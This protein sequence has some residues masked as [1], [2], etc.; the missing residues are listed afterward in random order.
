MAAKSQYLSNKVL[1]NALVNTAYTPPGTV[2][3]A[4]NTTAS[5][6]TAP[7][8]E[9]SDTHYARVATTFSTSTLG[10]TSNTSVLAFYGTGRAAGSA[11]IVEAAIYDNGSVGSGSELYFGTLAVPKTVSVG[12]TLSFA[13]GALSVSET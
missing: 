9:D 1:N 2:Y 4:L 10:I 8:T 13:I 7:G 5:T 3:L 11:N 6:A 12:D